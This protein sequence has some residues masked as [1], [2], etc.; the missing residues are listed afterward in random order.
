MTTP[1]A[2]RRAPVGGLAA[3]PSDAPHVAWLERIPHSVLALLARGSLGV[4]FWQSGQTKIAG[5]VADPV[6]LDLQPGW[7]RLS[8]S[9]VQL[10]RDEYAL[11]LIPP[12]L[13]A[14]MAAVA[15]HILPLLLVL[16]LASRWAALGLLFMT[17]V[18][19]VFVYPSAYATHGLWVM[20]FLYIAARGPGVVSLDALIAARRRRR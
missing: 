17:L 9:V 5:F 11:P 10:F 18:I 15:E 16:G 1:I 7:P 2:T 4:T 14:P 8:D 12:E 3:R 13:A 20:G 6:G 19:Q